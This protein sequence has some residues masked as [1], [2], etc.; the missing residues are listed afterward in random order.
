MH[1]TNKLDLALHIAKVHFEDKFD[2]G[3]S[4]YVDHLTR[5]ANDVPSCI[6]NTYRIVALLHDL[7]EDFPE[8]QEGNFLQYMFNKEI[9]E[10]VR[11]ITKF[12]GF[13][14]EEYIEE[15]CKNKIA[16]IVKL[17]DLRDN[18]NMSRLKTI[19]TKEIERLMKYHNAY[20]FIKSK[21]I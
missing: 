21:S 14:Y 10:A 2:Q 7:L 4:P 8:Y 20:S 9:N 11:A 1:I 15:V 3:L 18:M 17:A 6:D 5:V 16:M 12:P 13:T 19:G